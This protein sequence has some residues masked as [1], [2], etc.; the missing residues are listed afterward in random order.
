MFPVRT[1]TNLE[2][3]FHEPFTRPGAK[4]EQMIIPT[5]TAIDRPQDY[6]QYMNFSWLES[7]L[8]MRKSLA[9]VV[10]FDENS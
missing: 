7:D 3:E 2:T 9:N 5:S 1:I 10:S 6:K 8:K 4:R